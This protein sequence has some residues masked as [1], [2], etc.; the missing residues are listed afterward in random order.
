MDLKDLRKE[1]DRIDKELL[2]VLAERMRLIPSVAEYKKK[3]NIQR[4]QPEREKEV[5]RLRKE[6]ASKLN[7]NQDFIEKIF[8]VI[9]ED[10]HRIEKDIMEK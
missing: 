4:Y 7:L 2:V 1:I 10:A 3:N 9:I 6:I 5:I 8:K